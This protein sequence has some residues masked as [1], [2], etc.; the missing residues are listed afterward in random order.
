[1][2]LLHLE[3]VDTSQLHRGF[4]MS[5]AYQ[6][7]WFLLF[8]PLLKWNGTLRTEATG[9]LATSSSVPMA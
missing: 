8:I 7:L 2:L 4:E 5:V 1:M 3:L 9:C 6:F